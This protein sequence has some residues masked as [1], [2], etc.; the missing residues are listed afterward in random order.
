MNS[1]LNMIIVGLAGQGVVMVSRIIST[2]LF[3]AGEKVLTAEVPAT[4]HRFSLNWACVRSAP[5]VLHSGK[6]SPGEAN[7]LL[8]LEPIECLKVAIRY[9]HKDGIILH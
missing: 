7:L 8:G 5:Y 3:T 6:I 2:A 4:S 9:A 1:P